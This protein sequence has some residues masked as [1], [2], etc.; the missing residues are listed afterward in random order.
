M[1]LA[2]LICPL[3]VGT[4]MAAAAEPVEKRF[5]PDRERGYR[6]ERGLGAARPGFQNRDRSHFL[7]ADRP[8]NDRGRRPAMP[9]PCPSTCSDG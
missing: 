7:D 2:L 9:P 3:A 8:L 4:A 5:G 6:I 1:R